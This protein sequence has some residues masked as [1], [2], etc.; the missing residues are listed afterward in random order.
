[1]FKNLSVGVKLGVGFGV[2][3]LLTAA[4]ALVG[5]L[6]LAS[7][8]ARETKSDNVT[9]L[10]TYTLQARSAEKNFQLRG[11]Q[12]YADQVV[13]KVAELKSLALA[14]R[15][16]FSDDYNKKE[17]DAVVTAAAQ[18][19]DAFNRYVAAQREGEN[20]LARME[21]EARSLIAVANDVRAQQKD[22]ASGLIRE[23]AAP[24]RI[25]DKVAKADDANRLIKW[26]LEVRR[27]EKN[28]QLREDAGAVA[29]ANKTLAQMAEL[30]RDLKARYT[31]PK[32]Q[33]AADTVL[34]AI[35]QYGKAFD[36]YVEVRGTQNT[37]MAAMVEA[38]RAVT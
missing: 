37:A 10:G 34:D 35:T 3:L 1:M 25:E 11:E 21:D 18:Y 6:S 33:R 15:A 23:G 30:T 2:V 26:A 16:L 13:A 19:L 5:Y 27:H 31:N 8:T 36:H 20:V 28:Y 24:A 4:I 9:R 17:M 38:A 14:T 12:K 7:V 32:H 29:A 22:E